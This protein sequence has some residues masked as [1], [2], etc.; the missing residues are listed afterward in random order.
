MTVVIL[1]KRLPGLT[2]A[3]LERFLHR[4][5]KAVGLRGTINVLITS[6]RELRSLNSRFRGKDAPTDVLSF[7]PLSNLPEDFAGDI[8]IAADIAVR[9]AKLFGH[10]GADELRILVLHGVLHLAGYNHERDNGTMARKEQRLRRRLGLPLALIER[11]QQ[12]VDTGDSPVS[13]A[14]RKAVRKL[15]LSRPQANLPAAHGR[16]TRVHTNRATTKRRKQ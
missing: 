14:N 16:V 8:A 11:S 4:T 15:Q 10:S 3:M 1:R 9:N 6:S 7:P 5:T 13:S 2:E 12:R